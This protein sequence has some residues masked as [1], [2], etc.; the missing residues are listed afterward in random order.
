[1]KLKS[2]FSIDELMNEHLSNDFFI[3][4]FYVL[5]KRILRYSNLYSLNLLLFYQ[6]NLNT[7]YVI[8]I[9]CLSN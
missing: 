9:D 3:F 1:M 8:V 2:T 7:K 4:E 6:K 5:V